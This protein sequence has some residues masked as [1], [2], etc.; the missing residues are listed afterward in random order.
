MSTN[1]KFQKNRETRE[2]GGFLSQGYTIAVVPPE[3]S[4]RVWGGCQTR[5]TLP[6]TSTYRNGDRNLAAISWRVS[7]FAVCYSPAVRLH[8]VTLHS[9]RYLQYK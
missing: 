7:A 1:P 5:M 3:N 2:P 9:P 6:V 8:R 4:S